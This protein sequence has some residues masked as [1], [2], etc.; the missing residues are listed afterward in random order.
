MREAYGSWQTIRLHIHFDKPRT[1]LMNRVRSFQPSL[2]VE[3]WRV[4]E[5][6]GNSVDE[7]WH[8]QWAHGAAEQSQHLLSI[9]HGSRGDIRKHSLVGLI[10]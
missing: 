10:Q 1:D 3:F 7:F 9:S 6:Y 5:F 4:A 2:G 8:R